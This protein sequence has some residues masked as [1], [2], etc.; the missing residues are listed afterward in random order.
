MQ[1]GHHRCRLLRWFPK[2]PGLASSLIF[3]GLAHGESRILITTKKTSFND[4]YGDV[5]FPRLGVLY[6]GSRT[7]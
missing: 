6:W 4:S 1:F 5:E 7:I 3:F 2:N